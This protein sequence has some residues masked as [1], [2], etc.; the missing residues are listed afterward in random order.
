MTQEELMETSATL[1]YS[2]YFHPTSWAAATLRCA[3]GLL[4]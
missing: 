3:G 1:G 4:A 2:L